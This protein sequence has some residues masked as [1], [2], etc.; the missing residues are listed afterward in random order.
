MGPGAEFGLYEGHGPDGPDHTHDGKD[1]LLGEPEHDSL[2]T[3][4]GARQWNVAPLGL[5]LSIVR[6]GEAGPGCD[7]FY[8]RIE[9][10]Q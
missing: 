7:A 5:W 10:K 8:I 3:R 1:N 2:E 6:G 9:R 4:H